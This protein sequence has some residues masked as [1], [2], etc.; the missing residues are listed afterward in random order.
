MTLRLFNCY[1]CLLVQRVYKDDSFFLQEN[2]FGLPL[3]ADG[4][5]S[6]LLI[7][8]NKSLMLHS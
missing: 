5:L 4:T 2:T 8:V 3:L 7:T 1:Y 6:Y